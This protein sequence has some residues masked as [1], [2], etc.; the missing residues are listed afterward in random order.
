MCPTEAKDT[1]ME[2]VKA[3]VSSMA[4]LAREL[5]ITRGAVSQ[6]ERVPAERVGDVSRITGL[7]PDVIRPDLFQAPEAAE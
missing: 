1:G 4:S 5:D 6:W 7:S 2:A 3:A